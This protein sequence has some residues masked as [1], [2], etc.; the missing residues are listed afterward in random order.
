MND[1]KATTTQHNATPAKPTPLAVNPEGIPAE[2]RQ[3]R[4]WLTWRYEWSASKRRWDKPPRQAGTGRLAESDNPATWA[5]FEDALASYQ[6]GKSDGVG[7]VFTKDDPY[8]GIDLDKVQPG[9]TGERKPWADEEVR[10]LASYTE[11]SPSGMGVHV[12]VK[13]TLKA[14]HKD[15]ARGIEVY[16][17][18][19]YFTM[20]GVLVNGLATIEERQ[21]AVDDLCARY[22]PAKETP[23]PPAPAGTL[24]ISDAALLA[25]ARAAKN[26]AK[27]D[28]LWRGDWQAEGYPSQSEADAALCHMLAF[29]TQNDAGRI[30]GM[31]RQ[32]SLMRDKWNERHGERGTYGEITIAH[33]IDGTSEVYDPHHGGGN[34]RWPGATIADTAPSSPAELL[35]PY[36]LG[37]VVATFKKWLYMPDPSPLYINLAAVVANRMPGDPVWLLT[38]GVPGGGKTEIL[39]SLTRLPNTYQAATLTE[40]ALLSGTSKREAAAGAK[41]GLLREIGDFGILL[42]KD[43]GSFL[44]LNKDT[45]GAIL[46]ALREIYDGAWTRHVGT[47]GGRALHWQ[48]KIGLV[49]GATGAIDAH[50]SVMAILGERFVFYRLPELEET[51]HASGALGHIGQEQEMRAELARAVQ[52]LFISLEIPT[53]HPTMTQDEQQWLILLA[54]MTARCRAPVLRD[55]FSREVEQI[56]G[57]EAPTRLVLVFAKLLAGLRTIGL[58]NGEACRIILRLAKD[59]MP[60][61]RRKILDDLSAQNEGATTTD[62][63]TRLQ[64]PTVTARRAL[65]DLHCYGMVDRDAGGE[66]K[67]DKWA[68]SVLGAELYKGAQTFSEIRGDMYTEGESAQMPTGT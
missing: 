30:D 38:V 11:L 58:P 59:S 43:F 7:F 53:T 65:E 37:E 63:A 56:P 33:A 35:T 23:P 25:K 22:W 12:V 31:F 26:G 32:S 8:T 27:F 36:T 39:Q 62:I 29:W 55:T 57:A 64:T 44:T 24:D 4:Q 52:N 21:A 15:T 61:L 47:D 54:R 20:T 45:R 51:K 9:I 28:A 17:R 66:G 34:G 46:Q 49:G 19:R 60:Q 13:A 42:V 48:G 1:S 40:G 5:T 50:H 18:G 41:G 68:L 10:R 6:A 14:G 67:A 2:L 3:R 16:D